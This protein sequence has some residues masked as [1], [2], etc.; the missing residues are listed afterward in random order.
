MRRPVDTKRVDGCVRRQTDRARERD[1]HLLVVVGPLG[2]VV[3]QLDL[4]KLGPAL[5]AD[6]RPLALGVKV[7]DLAPAALYDGERAP[8]LVVRVVERVG[9]RGALERVVKVCRARSAAFSQPEP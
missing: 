4:V 5:G 9:R 6:A 1:A 2:L 3:A 8:P 7:D